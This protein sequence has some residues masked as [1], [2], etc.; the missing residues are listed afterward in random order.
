MLFLSHW[1]VTGDG[2]IR[3]HES[4]DVTGCNGN[5]LQPCDNPCCSV[6]SPTDADL[7]LIAAGWPSLPEAMRAGIVA[8]VRAAVPDQSRSGASEEDA[9]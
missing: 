7:A 5:D 4:P 2:G 1:Q 8:M 3:T 6:C 9:E